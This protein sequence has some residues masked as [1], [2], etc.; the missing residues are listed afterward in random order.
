MQFVQYRLRLRLRGLILSRG[1]TNHHLYRGEVDEPSRHR[2]GTSK[3]PYCNCGI[4]LRRL[5]SDKDAEADLARKAADAS[6]YARPVQIVTANWEV[7]EDLAM[8]PYAPVYAS[9]NPPGADVYRMESYGYGIDDGGDGFDTA[10]DTATVEFIVTEYHPTGTYTL[11]YITMR[12]S[13][14]NVTGVYFTGGGG[15]EDARTVDIVTT[16]PD[17]SFAEL[18]LNNISVSASPTNQG[19]PDGETVVTI[20]YYA[21]DDKSGLGLVQYRL[22]DPQ[23]I[24]HDEYHYHSNFYSLFFDGDPT[25]WQQYEINVVLPAGSAPGTWGLSMMVLQDKANNRKT[26]DF[27]EIVHFDVVNGDTPEDNRAPTAADLAAAG[28]EDTAIS[29]TVTASD[30][31]VGDVLAFS[32]TTD[33]ANGSVAM[34]TDGA[35]TYTPDDDY[36]GQDS[37]TFTVTDDGGLTDTGTVTLTVT[38]QADAPTA[39]DDTTT[40]TEDSSAN[41]VDVLANDTYLPDPAETLTVT[42]VTQ[43][44]NGTVAITGGGTGLSYQPDADYYGSDSFTYTITDGDALTDTATVSVTVNAD[45]VWATLGAG[46]ARRATYTDAD[47][48]VVVATMTGAGTAALL[49]RG[50]GLASS[51]TSALTITGTNVY[52]DD[53]ILTGTTADGVLAFNATG[54]NGRASIDVIRG[55]TPL[56]KLLAQAMDLT[57]AGVVLTGSGVIHQLRTGRLSNGADIVMPGTG[58]VS[59]VTIR[60]DRVAA[61][62]AITLGSPLRSLRAVEW[63]GGALGT[64]WA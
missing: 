51:G 34:G 25:Q 55:S 49:L 30:F 61:G 31:D 8:H 27:T 45:G 41:A 26:Y 10:T 6:S 14:L 12:D 5:W 53:V 47:G 50:D 1:T 60:A 20:E 16:D 15:D 56:G 18:D 29:D 3:L 37:F 11:N 39:S 58:A 22:R 36:Y 7:D 32:A 57:G 64:P 46:A 54:G 43:G 24:N 17:T 19:S 48:T 33:P 42:A 35:F 63:L 23:G 2:T 52:L 59:G 21:R 44:S 13:A 4:R 9:L 38:N 28:D 62:S 40:V